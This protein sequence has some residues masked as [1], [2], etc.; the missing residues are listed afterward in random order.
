MWSASFHQIRLHVWGSTPEL[1]PAACEDVRA[2]AAESMGHVSLEIITA[3]HSTP[4]GRQEVWRRVAVVSSHSQSASV[5][6]GRATSFMQ[7]TACCRIL[8]HVRALT[9]CGLHVGAAAAGEDST[10]RSE[11][12]PSS[13]THRGSEPRET[14][15]SSRA[16]LRGDSAAGCW[17]TSAC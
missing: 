14:R 6:S 4:A 2:S 9:H 12:A 17:I 3:N 16:M 7:A 11:I 10:V 5:D 8:H 1:V 15:H 13:H